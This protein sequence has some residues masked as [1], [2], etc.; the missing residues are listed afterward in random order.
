M[1]S[2]RTS[3]T[4]RSRQ[5]HPRHRTSLA[6]G[7]A[8]TRRLT[9][10][11]VVTLSLVTLTL[12]ASTLLVYSHLVRATEAEEKA[13]QARDNWRAQVTKLARRNY[14][15]HIANVD[16]ALLDEKYEHAQAELDMCDPKLRGWESRYL[17]QRMQMAS[18]MTFPGSSDPSSLATVSD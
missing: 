3:K 6:S 15:L 7:P 12:A 9:W 17:V 4:G 8:A 14:L 18:P 13:K 11:T 10:A 1:I 5:S 16:K 2:A